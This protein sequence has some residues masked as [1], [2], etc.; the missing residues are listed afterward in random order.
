MKALKL[1]SQALRFHYGHF[2]TLDSHY[3]ETQSGTTMKMIHSV[4]NLWALAV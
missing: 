3:R 4:H 1:I 2:S